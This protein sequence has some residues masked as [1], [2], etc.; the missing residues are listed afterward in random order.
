MPLRLYDETLP[1]NKRADAPQPC[2]SNHY[3]L[4]KGMFGST[5]FK[6]HDTRQHALV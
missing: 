6:L 2:Y 3:D 5:Y 4:R 1:A